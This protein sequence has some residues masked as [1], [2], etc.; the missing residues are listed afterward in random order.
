LTIE[1]L[2]EE[3]TMSFKRLTSKT[4]SV[5]SKVFL[6]K[7]LCSL[8]ISKENVAI[9]DSYDTKR[10]SA[11][12][13]KFKEIKTE[14]ICNYCKKSGYIKAKCF[15]SLKKNQN[16]GENNFSGLRNYVATTTRMGFHF[17]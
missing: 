14:V 4:Y 10:V 9:A 12:Q 17:D 13:G 15:K 6:T 16:Q 7:R 5:I 11:S 1:V 3:L 2:K 8:G